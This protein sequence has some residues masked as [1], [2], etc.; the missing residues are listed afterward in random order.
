MLVTSLFFSLSLCVCVY[1]CV[2]VCV[3]VCV[4]VCTRAYVCSGGLWGNWQYSV[5]SQGSG[6]L[7]FGYGGY[8]EARGS[9]ISKAKNNFYV[10]N[11]LALLDQPSEWY[12]DPA[13]GELFFFPNGSGYRDYP[14]VEVVAPLLDTVVEIDGAR[15]VT[16]SGF[17]FT[18]TRSSFLEQ[19]EVPSGGGEILSS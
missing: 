19:Y 2:R 8:Q 3:C 14:A 1:V 16:L 12:H 15:N 10:E 18:E 11:D 4:C 17:D 6:S 13:A 9:G 7:H 5:A